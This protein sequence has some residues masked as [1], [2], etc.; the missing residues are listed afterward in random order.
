MA[1]LTEALN[2]LEDRQAAAAALRTLIEKIV[3][4]PG[5][6]RGAIEATL[7]GELGT[8]INWLERQTAGKPPNKNTPGGVR[9]G[10]LVFGCGGWI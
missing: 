5:A 7:Y 2:C 9:A 8:L 3:L 6:K 1:Q 4:T 10:V